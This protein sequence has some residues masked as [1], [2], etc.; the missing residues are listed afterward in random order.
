MS[1]LQNQIQHKKGSENCVSMSLYAVINVW[2]LKNTEM[3]MSL[4]LAQ[5]SIFCTF[6]VTI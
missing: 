4:S 6:K 2:S 3:A 1:Y 5:L